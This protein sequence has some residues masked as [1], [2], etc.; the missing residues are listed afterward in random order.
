MELQKTEN[1]LPATLQQLSKSE[2]CR[3]LS[4]NNLAGVANFL[5]STLKNAIGQPPIRDLE[6][7]VGRNQI[8]R[9]I[10]FELVKMTTLVSVGNNLNDPQVQFIA[11][12]LVE[13]F[14]NESL[15]DFKLCFQR[16]C[17]GQYGEIYRMDGIVLRQWME[18][19]LDEKYQLVEEKL[20]TENHIDT[21]W[22][23]PPDSANEIDRLKQWKESIDS[24]EK[25]FQRPLTGDEIKEEGK[26]QPP[27]PK[28]KY[29]PF[30]EQEKIAKHLR[31]IEYIKAN[32]DARTGQPLASWMPESEWFDLKK[33]G[34]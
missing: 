29:Y 15:A 26:E 30:T 9:Y 8:V 1:K 2:L 12:Q 25:K 31:H 4:N 17:I 16:G 5:P 23:T 18:K 13:F 32:Y 20:K 10:E 21:H 19:Y 7:V 22:V 14:P 3:M 24:I 34:L 33:S 27:K 28:G 6:R 11:T